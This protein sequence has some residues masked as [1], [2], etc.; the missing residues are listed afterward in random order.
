MSSLAGKDARRD[1]WKGFGKQWKYVASLIL[2]ILGCHTLGITGNRLAITL[3][4][5]WTEVLQMLNSL[6]FFSLSEFGTYRLLC[7]TTAA[8]SWIVDEVVLLGA[9]GNINSYMRTCGSVT[10]PTKTWWS[11]PRVA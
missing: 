4:Y 2:G 9:D 7:P 5:D 11:R 3:R 8:C 1:R 10:H 6:I